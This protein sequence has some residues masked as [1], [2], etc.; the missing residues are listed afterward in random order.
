MN[1]EYNAISTGALFTSSLPLPLGPPN[2]T[3]VTNNANN[4]SRGII[5]IPPPSNPPFTRTSPSL[6]PAPPTNGSPGSRT[7]TAKQ[8]GT[9]GPARLHITVPSAP[10]SE[11]SSDGTIT[12]IQEPQSLESRSPTSSLVVESL[13]EGRATGYVPHPPPRSNRNSRVMVGDHEQL[14]PPFADGRWVES[15]EA[16]RER[17]RDERSRV[18]KRGSISYQRVTVPPPA[19]ELRREYSTSRSI[20]STANATCSSSPPRATVVQYSG[21]SDPIPPPTTSTSTRQRHDS[22]ANYTA[23]PPRAELSRRPS[24][25]GNRTSPR[26][27]EPKLDTSPRHRNESALGLHIPAES[28]CIPPSSRTTGGYPAPPPARP[29][30]RGS[31]RERRSSPP[32]IVSVMNGGMYRPQ[33][34]APESSYRSAPSTT[35]YRSQSSS[36]PEVHRAPPPSASSNDPYHTAPSS[37]LYRSQSTA[38]YRSQSTAPYR[39]QSTVPAPESIPH[40]PS[41]PSQ[42][43]STA[44]TIPHLPFSSYPP[45]NAQPQDSRVP[46][47]RARTNSGSWSRNATFGSSNSSSAPPPPNNKT[48]SPP[49]RHAQPATS[50]PPPRSSSRPNSPIHEIPPPPRVSDSRRERP[51]GPPPSYTASVNSSGPLQTPRAN[52]SPKLH[53][54]GGIDS[55]YSADP[56]GAGAKGKPVLTVRNP[57]PGSET[58]TERSSPSPASRIQQQ[59]QTTPTPPPPTRPPYGTTH[60]RRS[61]LPSSQGQTSTVNEYGRHTVQLPPGRPDH[62]HRRLSDGDQADRPSFSFNPGPDSMRNKGPLGRTVRWDE[63]LI[64]PS[65][66]FPN[67]RKGWFNRRGHSDQLWTNEGAYKPP[68]PGDDYPPDL[69]DYP[70]FGE[71]WMNEAGVKIDTQHRLIPKTPLRPALKQ[72]KALS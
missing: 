62:P 65:P 51:R 38:P 49:S 10:P 5:S 57:S 39:S 29:P 42:Q 68:A 58:S 63:N 4:P 37:E 46:P 54:D 44:A 15:Q 28:S 23:P 31:D 45:N 59:Q 13:E 30:S 19:P 14:L 7:S 21:P 56:K 50:A 69:D 16:Q 61:T 35:Q 47:T 17:E 2:T 6:Y 3:D 32:V 43:P 27:A 53:R 22:R 70:E 72:P 24:D 18:E 64:C 20:V 11:T 66:V 55:D 25:V 8:E 9:T 26:Q 36:P 33:T 34:T 71:G 12:M 67:R 52:G 41:H 1:A 40:R 48:P 60:G